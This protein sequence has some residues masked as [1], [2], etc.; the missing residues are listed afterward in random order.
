MTEYEL[1]DVT[2]GTSH[3]AIATISLYFTILTAYL[4]AAFFIGAKLTKSETVMIS[5]VFIAAALFFAFLSNAFLFRHMY[6]LDRLAQ[7]ETDTVHFVGVPMIV[8]VTT[9]KLLGILIGLKFMW[10]VRQ[11]KIE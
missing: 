10:D 3:G 2:I 4:I 7:I 8:V 1:V 11:R 5:I 6:F 9:I